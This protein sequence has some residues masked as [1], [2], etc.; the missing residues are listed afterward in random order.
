MGVPHHT[1]A[2]SPWSWSVRYVRGV[3]YVRLFISTNISVGVRVAPL[4]PSYPKCEVI[5]SGQA[6]RAPKSDISPKPGNVP[7]W[8]RSRKRDFCLKNTR[9]VQIVSKFS[10][11]LESLVSDLE[12]KVRDRDTSVKARQWA[13]NV[14][15]QDNRV[16]ML[17]K[18]VPDIRDEHGEPLVADDLP[19]SLA[20]NIRDIL[21]KV[22]K[23]SYSGN[24]DLAAIVAEI[25]AKAAVLADSDL[26]DELD[27]TPELNAKVQ[28]ALNAYKKGQAAQERTFRASPTN[29][30]S[31]EYFREL[32]GFVQITHTDPN[33]TIKVIRRNGDYVGARYAIKEIV[34]K[35]ANA[36]NL[37]ES[38]I[39]SP[40]SQKL[41]DLR[42]A[43]KEANE[44]RNVLNETFEDTLGN[45]FELSFP[46]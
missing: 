41:T 23:S 14:I 19:L 31:R 20:P 36:A 16:Q 44:S 7:N 10:E 21:E 12:D 43:V 33:G 32:D 18:D 37:P 38:D 24:A 22:T 6:P 4:C 39:W 26:W 28:T 30:S 17:R 5:R 1:R 35:A 46:V 13:Q 25:N 40:I 29:G 3:R 8:T 2:S 42:E 9:K 11:K 15:D 45:R 34:D 27:I